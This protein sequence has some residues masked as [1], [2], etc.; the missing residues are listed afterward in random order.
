LPSASST[1]GWQYYFNAV[2]LDFLMQ[3]VVGS[4]RVIWILVSALTLAGL[5]ALSLDLAA[6]QPARYTYYGKVPER[7][8][9]YAYTTSGGWQIMNPPVSSF[10]LAIGAIEPDTTVRVVDLRTKT[11]IFEHTFSRFEKQYVV[12]NNGTVFKVSSNKPLNVLL[13]NLQSPPNASTGP[14]PHAFYPAVDGTYVGKRFVI[15]ASSDLNPWYTIFALEDS[16]VSISRE[17]GAEK[18]TFRLRANEYKRVLLR[19]WYTYEITSTGNIMVQCGDPHSYWDTHESYAIP[20]A[21]GTFVGTD[22]FSYSNLQWDPKEDVGFRVFALERTKVTVYDLEREN[23]LEEFEMEPFSTYR[24][25][26]V[27]QAIRVSSKHP[28]Q[29]MLVHE[30][31]ATKMA[32]R[33][34]NRE[35]AY[36]AGV[37]FYT[38]PAGR[39]AVVYLPVNSTG[40]IVFFASDETILTID[41]V[42]TIKLKPDEFYVLTQP[43]LHTVVADRDLAVQIIHWPKYPEYQGLWVSGTVLPAVE[44][45]GLAKEVELKEVAGFAIDVR[46]IIA[47]VALLAAAVG[48]MLARRRRKGG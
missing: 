44:T 5:L 24:F 14:V 2:Q 11:V 21:S 39:K 46:L 35:N 3:M 34:A 6:A 31:D 19:S 12:L 33:Q 9:S 17:D 4:Q 29:V 27:T 16:E 40:E 7:I 42:T 41:D 25:Q 28:I 23:V 45:A 48:L 26:A 32:G 37:V 22:F 36:G 10:L 15:L 30:G 47:A 18:Q 43:G 13:L 8:W 20:S 1:A 38:L